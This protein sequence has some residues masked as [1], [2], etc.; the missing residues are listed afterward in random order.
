MTGARAGAGSRGVRFVSSLALFGVCA[1]GVPW[2][3]TIAARARFDGA[4]PLHGVPAPRDWERARI[5]QALTDQLTEDTIADVV[6]R[7]CLLV[8]WAAVIVLV[9]TVVAEAAHMIRHGGLPMPDVRGL[10]APQSL[11]RV[12]AAGFLVV[13]PMLTSPSRATAR[14][15]FTLEARAPATAE[16]TTDTVT[17]T[18]SYHQHHSWT[19][20]EAP[21][22][23]EPTDVASEQRAPSSG[24]AVSQYVVRAGDSVYAIA[25]RLVGP[26]AAAVSAYAERL[27]DLNLGREMP[28]GQRFTNAAYIDVGWVLDLP[29]DLTVEP[30][31]EPGPERGGAADAVEGHVVERGETLWS[32][33]ED[34]LGDPRRW[35]EIHEANRGRTFDDGRTF[36]DPSLIQPGWVL[37]VPDDEGD[38]GGAEIDEE[39]D[40]ELDVAV[41][42]PTESPPG[43]DQLRET[44]DADARP[45]TPARPRP[46]NRWTGVPPADGSV[47]PAMPMPPPVDPEVGQDRAAS[48]PGVQ[49]LTFGRAAML[50]AG[51]LTLLA[52]RRRDHLRRARPRTRLAEPAP[53]VTRTERTLRS[54]DAGDRFV[55]VDIAVRSV[56]GALVAAGE[57]VVAITVADDGRL[58]L[59][60]S[61]PV[62]LDG[63]WCPTG[64]P[65]RWQLPASIPIELLAEPAR[66]VGAPCPAL[67]QLGRT[68]DA[69]DVYVDLEALEAIEI[70][71]PGDRADAIVTAIAATLAGSV[72]AEV[73]TL[74]GV[75]LDDAAFLGHR[76]HVPARDARAAFARAAHAVG[77]TA[78]KGRSTF[79][80]RALATG[81]ET[82]EPA[83]VLIGASAGTVTPPADRTALALVSASPIH[84]PSSRLEPDGDAWV[85]RPLGLRCIPIGLAPDDLA[86]LAALVASADAEVVDDEPIA[87]PVTVDRPAVRVGPDDDV[88]LAPLPDEP[89]VEE[90]VEPAVVDGRETVDDPA[91]SPPILVCLLGP[92]AIRSADGREATFEKSKAKELIAWL[93]THRERST[94]SA[95]RTALWEL[96]V[97]DATFANV[98]SEARRSLARL[99]EPPEGEEWIGRT[100]TEALPLHELVRTD[101]DVVRGAL[102]AAR[103][104]PPE[105][106]IATLRPAVD[107]VVGM[108]FEGTGYLWPEAEGI[109]SALVLLATS[110]TA[111]LGAHC[112]SMGDIDGV[113]DATGRG[114]RVLPGHDELIGLRMRAHARAGDR[115]GVRHEWAQYE[116]VVNADP[117]SDGE[118]SPTL[119]ELRRELLTG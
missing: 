83:I 62:M 73:T 61:G 42:E 79:E 34:E 99:V 10:G 96:D 47:S 63:P 59:C 39:I 23:V 6:V 87:R 41:R 65:T 81:G 58:G 76:R 5:R 97:R 95:A 30:A 114:L 78:V 66:R 35:P 101:A 44:E 43:D 77:T 54:I 48:E 13:V 110:V 4:S 68:T 19:T 22:P 103:L 9:V 31:L 67:V 71:G 55:R 113:F 115:A 14:D 45:A 8:A 111:E 64:D 33:A 90:V 118:P 56:A 32:I 20:R 36:E 16:A 60:T 40:D 75:G 116:R 7:A 27:V 38:V 37:R 107:L 29:P 2:G 108:P 46:S 98:V 26:D 15:G 18:S 84:G 3:L 70:G 69:Q 105:Q 12:I 51:V 49:L 94:R 80:L 93:A 88:T 109:A 72:L 119:I 1:V 25:A 17:G 28:G 100:L 21:V 50:A 52:V 106:A 112:L 117:W 53:V 91:P 11:A 57:R 82:W 74:V 102:D 86:S 89:V 24:Q 92:V 104:Q 85:L